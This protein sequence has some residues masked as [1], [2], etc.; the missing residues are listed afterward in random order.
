M[1]MGK[2][3]KVSETARHERK[4][5][6]RSLPE[7]SSSPSSSSSEHSDTEE[8]KVYDHHA[9]DG[10]EPHLNHK[11][12]KETSYQNPSFDP[13]QFYNAEDDAQICSVVPIKDR[14]VV[15]EKLQRIHLGS[16]L[17]EKTRGGI[18]QY[19]SIYAMR[20]NKICHNLTLL[21]LTFISER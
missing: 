8:R 2:P 3:R 19:Y 12:R 20:R 5:V 1:K 15:F 14:K 16:G 4:E 9:K 21:V 13:R 7:L 18:L 10:N 11:H 17:G 6:W